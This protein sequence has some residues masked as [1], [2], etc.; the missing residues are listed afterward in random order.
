MNNFKIDFNSLVAQAKIA[1]GYHFIQKFIHDAIRARAAGFDAKMAIV[2]S[3]IGR[4][5][6]PIKNL[7]RLDNGHDP[8]GALRLAIEK[9]K[10]KMNSMDKYFE[11]EAERI[12]YRN[13]VI[14]LY[15]K[16][17]IPDD[18]YT[19]KYVYI[20]VRQDLSPEYQLVQAAHAAAKM[21]HRTG[22]MP[23]E[24]FD[25]LY[26]SVIG[27]PDLAAL[28]A[29]QKDFA[30]RGHKTHAFI[31]PDIGN[32]MTAFA[33]EPIYMNERKGLLA[34]KRLK[35]AQPTVKIE[36]FGAGGGPGITKAA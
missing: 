27:V 19:R 20:F 36:V 16:H 21:G 32:V 26:F 28:A 24:K 3:K 35:F 22:S 9:T 12:L 6:R 10:M 8:H 33:S 2:E 15:Q 31:E 18:Y 17:K 14:A 13:I 7:K 5:F 4:H 11:T 23:N 30:D 34:Y 25:Q 29:A 1:Q